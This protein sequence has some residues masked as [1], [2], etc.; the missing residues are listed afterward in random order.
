MVDA[1]ST[2]AER[3]ITMNIKYFLQQVAERIAGKRCEQCKYNGGLLCNHPNA[4]VNEKC[5]NCIFPCGFEPK[6]E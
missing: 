1:A 2:T 6:G 3:R 4:V 5:R